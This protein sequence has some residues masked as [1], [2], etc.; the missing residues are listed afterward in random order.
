MRRTPHAAR[1]SRMKGAT[2]WGIGELLAI[3]SDRAVPSVV[4]ARRALRRPAY[5]PSGARLH[6]RRARR[7]RKRPG[8]HRQ[9]LGCD[10]L[11]SSCRWPVA[12]PSGLEAPSRKGPMS[13]REE[14]LR[15]DAAWKAARK[16][17]SDRNEA[18]YARGREQRAAR[19][20]AVARRRIEEERR[21][22]RD[23]PRPPKV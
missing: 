19:D 6:G 11:E 18:A 4:R 10:Y 9:A 1:R 7:P 20:A 8:R 22:D 16:S 23:L 12:T 14:P 3:G 15:G 2:S 17:V 5:K 13:K 21:A